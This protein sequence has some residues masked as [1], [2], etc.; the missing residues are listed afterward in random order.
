MDKKSFVICYDK[1]LE[2]RANYFYT[3]VS[4][5]PKGRTVKIKKKEF[6][7]KKSTPS[8]EYVV[9]LGSDCSKEKIKNFQSFY[10]EFG[11]QM[12]CYG[13]QAWISWEDIA[14]EN[15]DIRK[16]G[17][18]YP[19]LMKKMKVREDDLNGYFTSKDYY[20][21]KPVEEG[22]APNWVIKIGWWITHLFP[23][24]WIFG[25]IITSKIKSRRRNLLYKYAITL[26]VSDYLNI[27]LGIA[28]SNSQEGNIPYDL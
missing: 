6:D 25:L 28:E 26:F 19:S 1:G 10:N 13:C 21:D 20:S 18:A 27:F 5:H 3:L 8:D 16:F 4:N 11:I 17:E 14:W 15:D 23:P 7:N 24:T 2:E 9:F 22:K 12:G